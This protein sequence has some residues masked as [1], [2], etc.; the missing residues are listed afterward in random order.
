MIHNTMKP[1]TQPWLSVLIPTYNGE[2]YINFTLDSILANETAGI[3][4]IVVDDESK[5]RT[6]EIVNSYRERLNIRIIPH[7]RTGNWVKNTN[8]ALSHA[9]TSYACLLHQ[10]DYWLPARLNKIKA[11]IATN[12]KSVLYLHDATYVGAQNQKLGKWSCPFPANLAQISSRELIERLIIQDFIAICS[13]VFRCDAAR[14]VGGL[15]ET[16]WYTADWDFWLKIALMG[17]VSYMP[18]TLSAFRVHN[19]SQT[20]Q[21]STSTNG[22]RSQ[23]DT[24]LTRHLNANEWLPG[25]IVKCAKFSV[26]LNVYLA[27]IYHNQ[28]GN[29]LTI[30]L[31][32]LSLGAYGWVVYIRNSRIIQ[33]VVSRVRAK[34]NA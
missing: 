13:P 2:K 23:L 1:S 26:E 27:N 21:R 15:D 9:T 3:E 33:R 10:D 29:H 28:K 20:I 18:Y 8:L 4:I 17:S 16:L 31:N 22:F 32:F 6:I 14:A 11:L 5:D 25:T 12:P 30:F 24:V 34:L 7:V 19:E